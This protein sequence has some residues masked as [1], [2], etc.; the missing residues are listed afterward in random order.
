MPYQRINPQTF[1]TKLRAIWDVKHG[2]YTAIAVVELLSA[3]EKS[4]SR[5]REEIGIGVWPTDTSSVA[6]SLRSWD[7]SFKTFGLRVQNY[8][9]EIPPCWGPSGDCWSGKPGETM[10]QYIE[11]WVIGPILDG[12][13]PKD[14]D[15]VL[16]LNWVKGPEALNAAALWNGLIEAHAVNESQQA[17]A[18]NGTGLNIFVMGEW[19]FAVER[20]LS[21]SAPGEPPTLRERVLAAVADIVEAG[22][23]LANDLFGG[24]KTLAGGLAVAA[25]VA[26][27]GSIGLAIASRRRRR[28]TPRTED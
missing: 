22:E 7:R 11:T 3:M 5:L 15:P 26:L 10:V 8:R 1:L 19:L 23:D 25:G 12:T 16:G 24:L 28:A 4:M 6:Q 18:L 17:Q 20:Q 21:E 14:E 27:F 13:H 9:D 2:R